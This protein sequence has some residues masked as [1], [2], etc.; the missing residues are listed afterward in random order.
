MVQDREHVYFFL[1]IPRTAGTTLI[2]NL[3]YGL[4][5]G[6]DLQL[7]PLPGRRFLDRDEV[8]R[9]VDS[10]SSQQRDRI[11]VVHGHSVYYG[12]H[13]KFERPPRY[14]TFLRDPLSRALSN[15]QYMLANYD[16]FLADNDDGSLP[17]DKQ[18]LSFERW[19][20]VFQH[21]LQTAVVLNYLLDG[22]PGW[23]VKHALA[24][25]DLERARQ[26]LDR[27]Y[28]VG[29]TE[30]FEE[31]SLFLYSQLGLEQLLA[32]PLN[33]RRGPPVELS[34]ELRDRV[35]QDTRLDA[36]LY[37]HAKSLHL[38]FTS[39]RPTFAEEGQALKARVKTV[40]PLRRRVFELVSR[41]IGLR[42]AAR[43]RMAVARLAN[44]AQRGWR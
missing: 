27:F 6:S 11:R 16:V 38:A 9:H 35:V 5:K 17:R 33:V 3:R 32:E 25:A 37:E 40:F 15:Y 41:S 21:D 20:S 10:L 43:L 1:H 2:T 12:I 44:A 4:P 24:P 39:E 8:D 19:W 30:T 29:L 31:D 14:V 18:E 22:K 26:I 36:Q 28:F 13:E 34:P 23:E 42:R 7:S